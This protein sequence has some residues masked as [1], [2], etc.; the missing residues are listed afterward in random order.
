[1]TPQKKYDEQAIEAYELY[2][3]LMGE[4]NINDPKKICDFVNVKRK[5]TGFP[6]STCP[7]EIIIC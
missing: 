7:Q 2:V 4:K 5:T 3:N 1:M 6:A